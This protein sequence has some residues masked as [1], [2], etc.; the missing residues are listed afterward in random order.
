MHIQQPCRLIHSQIELK[1]LHSVP[2]ILDKMRCHADA[3]KRLAA[4]CIKAGQRQIKAATGSKRQ[5]FLD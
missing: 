1:V 5:Q 4:R 3:G 2:P